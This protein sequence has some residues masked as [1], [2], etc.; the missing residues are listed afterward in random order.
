MAKPGEVN[1][2]V[3]FDY[4]LDVSSLSSSVTNGLN[5]ST[6]NS[7]YTNFNG[8]Y[9]WHYDGYCYG[10]HHNTWWTYPATPQKVYMYQIECPKCKTKTFGELDTVVTC[11]SCSS[12]IKLVSKVTDYEVA[13]DL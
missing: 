9:H 11:K 6:G 10:C 7:S 1:I 2:P 13:V 12:T 3:K 5:V 4:V 8:T